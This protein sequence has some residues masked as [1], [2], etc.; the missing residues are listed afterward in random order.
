MGPVGCASPQITFPGNEQPCRNKRHL[1]LPALCHT[2][3]IW[4]L[5][6][7]QW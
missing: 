6:I 1:T 4:G 7:G 5:V 2:A 3:C